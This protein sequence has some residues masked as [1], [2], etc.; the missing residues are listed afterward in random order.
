MYLAPLTFY[1]IAAFL[2]GLS[3]NY[4]DPGLFHP[5]AKPDPNAPDIS[6]SPII[7]VL[8]NTS[9]KALPT[10]LNACFMLSGYTAGCVQ[11]NF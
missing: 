7:I 10:F 8:S 5:W 3:I 6:H 1:I 9:L 2:I 4:M 11:P